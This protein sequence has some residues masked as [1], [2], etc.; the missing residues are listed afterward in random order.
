MSTHSHNKGGAP[1]FRS[2]TSIRAHRRSDTPLSQPRRTILGL[3]RGTLIA[4]AIATIV[5]GALGAIFVTSNLARSSAGG[6]QYPYKVGR[7]GPG[8]SAPPIEL[9][10]TAGGTFDLQGLGGKTV[11][12]FFEE[13]LTCQPCWDQIK[14]IETHFDQFQGLGIDQFVAI[15]SDPLPALKQKVADDGL[16][17]PVLADVDLRVSRLYQ[18]DQYTMMPAMSDMAGR[19]G[20]SFVLVNK[21]GT[22]AW[23]ADYGGAPKYTMYVPSDALLSDIKKGLL[24]TQG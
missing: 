18:A 17:T 9:P 12:L 15:T 3:R 13:G 8:A 23:R 6:G 21:D 4:V 19:D 1:P 22:I 16:T 11:L 14:D 7:P 10:S 2:A 20:H 5:V 24:G